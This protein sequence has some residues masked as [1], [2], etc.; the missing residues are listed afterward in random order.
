MLN[1]YCTVAIAS[2][3]LDGLA[4]ALRPVTESAV[5]LY[6]VRNPEDRRKPMPLLL[7]SLM[8]TEEIIHK[9]MQSALIS[10]QYA[11][12]LRSLSIRIQQL[13]AT[14]DFEKTGISDWLDLNAIM[15]SLHLENG[16]AGILI[17]LSGTAVAL[18]EP[19]LLLTDSDALISPIRTAIEY[20]RRWNNVWYLDEVKL[21]RADNAQQELRRMIDMRK[22]S[23]DGAAD[24]MSL[25]AKLCNITARIKAMPSRAY[26][27]Y[28]WHSGLF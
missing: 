27:M 26:K 17:N 15:T 23:V 13:R 10:E 1:A 3:R 20:G 5:I 8:V 16:A 28:Y 2:S 14:A 7:P 12:F 11:N 19:L 22:I 25:L 18:I 21:G 4:S 24:A 9:N 6:V